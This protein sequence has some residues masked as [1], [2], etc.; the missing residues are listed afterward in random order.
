MVDFFNGWIR[1]GWHHKRKHLCLYGESNVGKSTF[2]NALLGN[3][4]HQNFPIGINDSKFAFDRWNPKLYTHCIAHEFDFSKIDMTTWKVALEGLTFK[5]NRKHKTGLEGAIQVPFI[6]ICNSNPCSF[7]E[8]ALLNRIEFVDCTPN[9]DEK[10]N[11]ISDYLSVDLTFSNHQLSPE[12]KRF[13]PIGALKFPTS[14]YNAEPGKLNPQ[15][16]NSLIF[17]E[18]G[19]PGSIDDDSAFSEICSTPKTFSKSIGIIIDFKN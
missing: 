7:L 3:Y 16:E 6:F 9:G 17:D 2:C 14:D 10:I 12:V 8:P 5:I 13:Y 11:D 18:A 19:N 15:N 4:E 1:D